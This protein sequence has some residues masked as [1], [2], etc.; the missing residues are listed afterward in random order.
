MLS[1]DLLTLEPFL[2]QFF[3]R[4]AR[5]ALK[6]TEKG[7]QRSRFFCI[8]VVLRIVVRVRKLVHDLCLS[9]QELS[10]FKIFRSCPKR[11]E[12]ERKH[13]GGYF[14][15]ATKFCGSILQMVQPLLHYLCK[16]TYMSAIAQCIIPTQ[17]IRLYFSSTGGEHTQSDNSFSGINKMVA[18]QTLTGYL[19]QNNMFWHVSGIY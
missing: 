3:K 12:I 2:Q 15:S 19:L 8:F 1:P 7:V 11:L 14:I 4:T 10:F 5:I 9:K 17:K 6:S 13:R 18:A 16:A